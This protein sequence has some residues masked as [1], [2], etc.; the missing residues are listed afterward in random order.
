MFFESGFFWLLMGIVFVVVAAGFKAF[1]DD[2]GWEITW[3][4][5]VLGLI[6]YTIFSMSFLA[7]GTLIGE[8][9]AGAGFKLFL[10]G[11]IVSVILGTGL[12]RLMAAKAEDKE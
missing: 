5:A 2:R 1:A 4:K 7:W 6:W 9:E 8:G 3:W 11:L 10:V 12:W